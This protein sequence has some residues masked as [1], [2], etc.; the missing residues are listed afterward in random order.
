VYRR[1]QRRA[2]EDSVIVLQS[3]F[4]T[5]QEHRKDNSKQERQ[6]NDLEDWNESSLV[7]L[8]DLEAR[9]DFGYENSTLYLCPS[10]LQ[11]LST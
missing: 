1:S 11:L 2:E 6:L 3:P 9:K 7:K 10:K 5:R 8:Q 4:C